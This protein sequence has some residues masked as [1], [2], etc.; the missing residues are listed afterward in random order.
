MN[1]RPNGTRS[2]ILAVIIAGACAMSFVPEARAAQLRAHA[3]G[4]F[5]PYAHLE[6]IR[7]D[8]TLASAEKGARFMTAVSEALARF[9]ADFSRWPVPGARR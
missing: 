5:V 4:D 7:R 2:K 6:R 8:P 1:E 9:L 3:E